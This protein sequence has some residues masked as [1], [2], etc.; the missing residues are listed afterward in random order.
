MMPGET[1]LSGAKSHKEDPHISE[2]IVLRSAA[3][4]YIGTIQTSDEGWLEPNTR[5]TDYFDSQEEAQRALEKYKN[6]GI[7]SKQR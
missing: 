6:T 7:L 4:W 3:G 5:E 1:V 2:F